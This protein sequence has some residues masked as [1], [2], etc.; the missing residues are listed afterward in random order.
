MSELVIRHQH[1]RPCDP[2]EHLMPRLGTSAD[3]HALSHL[4]YRAP[5]PATI[6][7]VLT[8]IDPTDALSD[9]PAC[10]LVVSRPTLNAWWRNHAW[11]GLAALDK[12]RRAQW[13]NAHVRTISRVIVHPRWRGLGVAQL[14]VRLYLADPITDRTEAS[15]AMGSLS[16]FFQRAGMERHEGSSSQRLA[17]QRLLRARRVRPERLTLASERAKLARDRSLIDSLRCWARRTRATRRLLP[18]APGEL[19]SASRAYIGTPVAYTHG[20]SFPIEHP[21]GTQP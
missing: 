15:A 7:R 13:L 12:R 11:P 9:A 14:I 2:L 20:P 3:Y 19:I 1:A 8:L 17:L 6:E 5:D 4:H 16:D 18:L 10:V 21:T